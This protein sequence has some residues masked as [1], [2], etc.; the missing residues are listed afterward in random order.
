MSSIVTP[1]FL[2]R[3]QKDTKVLFRLKPQ[4]T[5]Y[6][7]PVVQGSS[8]IETFHPVR[9]V[10]TT[11]SKQLKIASGSPWNWANSLCLYLPCTL[12]IVLRV[13]QTSQAARKTF[14]IRPASLEQAETS[15][16]TRRFRPGGAGEDALHS[17]LCCQQAVQSA[18]VSSSVSC[19]S[20]WDGLWRY[21]CL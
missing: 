21:T 13:T 20:C 1:P 8:K 17:L 2:H 18:S 14:E 11:E 7:Y 3:I 4:I 10:L 15:Q 5:T 12:T 6:C 19:R 9:K 16:A